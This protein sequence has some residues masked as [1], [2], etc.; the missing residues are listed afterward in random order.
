MKPS[1]TITTLRRRAARAG[2]SALII[3]VMAA[4]AFAAQKSA[5]KRL[6]KHGRAAAQVK[7]AAITSSTIMEIEQAL[8]DLGYWTGPVDGK[9]DEGSRHALIAFQKVESR[10]VTGRPSRGELMALS[11]AARPEAR[12]GGRAQIEIDLSRQVLFMV[13]ESGRVSK[14]LPVSTG[15]GKEFT[16]EGWTRQAITPAG[17]FKVSRKIE[18]WRKSPLGLIYYPVYFLGGVAIHGY[19]SVPSQPASHGCVRIP[20]FAAK[21]FHE[22]VPVGAWVVIHN[23]SLDAQRSENRAPRQ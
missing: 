22:T 21:E 11:N 19:S 17:R 15:N 9:W 20:M 23:G 3:A 16:S 14:T 6:Q 1:A 4:G 18:G 7:K 13:D 2:L 8:S 10:K 5:A 12:E